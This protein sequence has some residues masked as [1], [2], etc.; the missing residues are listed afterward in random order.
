MVQGREH[1]RFRLKPRE[2]IVVACERWWQ[3]L[4]RDWAFQLCIDGP[5]HLAHTALADRRGDFVDAET[6]A[7]R[8]GQSGVII[9]DA[10]LSCVTV[11]HRNFG[12]PASSPTG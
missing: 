7:G 6:G 9:V 8:E 12:V 4:D 10:E 1:F 3:D 5:I 2:S 11:E